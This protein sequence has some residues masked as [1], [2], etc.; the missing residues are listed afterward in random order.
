MAA[1]EIVGAR[2]EQPIVRL[3]ITWPRFV[4]AV[5]RRRQERRMLA[6]LSRLPPHVIRDMG[7]DPE[8]VYDAV[9][10]TWGEVNPG[11]YRN[12]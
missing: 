9:E 1:I 3:V 6:R 5:I 8:R 2:F 11:R 10:G 4:L 12:R 7:V